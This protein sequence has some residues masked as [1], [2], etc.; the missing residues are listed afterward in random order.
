MCHYRAREKKVEKQIASNTLIQKS[1]SQQRKAEDSLK[2]KHQFLILLK[3]SWS[4]RDVGLKT[5]FSVIISKQDSLNNF[6]FWNLKCSF[7]GS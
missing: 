4:L 5:D 2:C 3:I 6:D 7:C 1:T